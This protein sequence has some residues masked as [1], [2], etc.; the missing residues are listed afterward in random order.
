[1]N[2]IF[3]K[4]WYRHVP[5]L[6]LSASPIAYTPRIK[7]RGYKTLRAYGS[8]F[9]LLGREN[10]NAQKVLEKIFQLFYTTKPT[11]QGTG[12]GLSL[13]YDIVKAHGGTIT[14]ES[15]ENEGSEFIIQ[16]PVIT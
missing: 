6:R 12:L 14:V 1:M 13:S 15:Y 9:F 8:E 11:G 3:L 7:I 4:S 16:I 5:S 10:V 2:N